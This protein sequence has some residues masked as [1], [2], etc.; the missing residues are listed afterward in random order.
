MQR[1]K[2]N[3]FTYRPFIKRE[4]ECLN[5]VYFRKKGK[6]I[7]EEYLSGKRII[8]YDGKIVYPKNVN[9][10]NCSFEAC[11]GLEVSESFNELKKKEL[12]IE[13]NEIISDLLNDSH[14][15]KDNSNYELK[16]SYKTIKK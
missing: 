12:L 15:V 5:N 1:D 13:Y 11:E 16:Y 8:M 4:E 10:Y 14:F 2:N 3:N 9:I 6:Y 7:Y